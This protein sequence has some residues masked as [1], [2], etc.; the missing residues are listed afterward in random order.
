MRYYSILKLSGPEKNSLGVLRS[1]RQDSELIHFNA[2]KTL[3][4]N[5]YYFQMK[6]FTGFHSFTMPFK[7]RSYHLT[8]LHTEVGI[9]RQMKLNWL[10]SS[11][12]LG[13][14]QYSQEH[15]KTIVY[16]NFEGQRECIMGY[17]KIEHTE[18]NN[19]TA[20]PHGE[21]QEFYYLLM[22]RNWILKTT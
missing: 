18:H 22:R 1:A 14:M 7:F 9:T 15:L 5:N 8:C 4:K 11:N 20:A 10:L 13:K 16:A 3:A 6:Y 19:L 17:S 12:T 21:L 2:D